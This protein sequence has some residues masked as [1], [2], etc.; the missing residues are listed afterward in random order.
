MV[1][2]LVVLLVTLFMAL[3]MTVPYFYLFQKEVNMEDND[4]RRGGTAMTF[5]LAAVFVGIG[6]LIGLLQSF[7]SKRPI[8]YITISL[9]VLAVSLA[10]FV[11]SAICLWHADCTQVNINWMRLVVPFAVL[12]SVGTVSVALVYLFV[13]FRDELH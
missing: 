5:T 11:P 13:K 6:S 1:M 3:F 7:G 2:G 8:I 10:M 4:W 9:L 12:G